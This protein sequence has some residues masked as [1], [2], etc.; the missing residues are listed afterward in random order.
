MIDNNDMVE[1]PAA[2]KTVQKKKSAPNDNAPEMA[3]SFAKVSTTKVIAKT[4]DVVKKTA[5]KRSAKKP[6]STK[7]SFILQQLAT[8]SPEVRQKMI[9]DAAYFKAEKRNFAPGHE[10]QDW[11][12]AEREI[13][14]LI[15]RA[16]T[17]T[18]N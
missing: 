13:D 4:T 15:N 16:K 17:A 12:D 1:K 6:A 10:V 2:K 14:E 3:A 5:T 8:V 18:G 9:E 7:N 11:A